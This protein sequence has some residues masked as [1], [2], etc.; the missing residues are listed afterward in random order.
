MCVDV[1]GR[2]QKDPSPA[3]SDCTIDDLLCGDAETFRHPDPP[4]PVDGV[5]DGFQPTMSSSVDVTSTLASMS[6]AALESG[7]RHA[8]PSSVKPRPTRY[9]RPSEAFLEDKS[10]SQQAEA[11]K[12]AGSK[13][14]GKGVNHHYVDA[15]G[16]HRKLHS[17]SLHPGSHN[18]SQRVA[19]SSASTSANP[20][21]PSRPASTVNSN[22]NDRPALR[23][24]ASSSS[25][26]TTQSAPPSNPYYTSA[27]SVDSPLSTRAGTQSDSG[28]NNNKA[29]AGRAAS[30][31]VSL[32]GRGRKLYWMKS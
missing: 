14:Q 18:N 11:D 15:S 28:V 30:A 8:P 19:Y 13:N 10:V 31:R 24:P 27:N 2:T 29:R 23:R 32:H 16:R 26:S 7:W 12:G 9:V 4:A 3:C 1:P 17:S 6:A 20:G 5:K 25:L 22:G 21:T